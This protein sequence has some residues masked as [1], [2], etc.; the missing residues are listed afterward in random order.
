MT[1]WPPEFCRRLAGAGFFVIRY[2]NRDAGRSTKVRAPVS[3][4]TVVRAFFGQGP[5]PPYT[6]DDMAADGM[7]VLDDLG[8]PS[9]HVVGMSMGG[10]I[11]QTMALLHPDRVRSLT[12]IMSTTGRRS[13]GW[14][15]PRLLPLLLAR[16]EETREAYVTSSTR[17]WRIIGSPG[18]PEAVE[19]V[20]KRAG[21]TYDRGVNSA[22]VARQMIAVLRQP[23]RSDR[24]RG[25][26]VPALVIHGL[27]DR[28][29]H[30]SGGRATAE[31]LPDAE[32]LLVP[33]MG[34]DLPAE[35]YDTFV[36][37]IRRVAERAKV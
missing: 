13:V 22:A 30:V 17:F 29:V 20:R 33:G 7:G 31:A 2:D 6:L 16:S 5:R 14:Q 3:R 12:S 11:A 36:D 24:L 19:A 21:E 9:A 23:D 35:L 10:M 15:D 25:L 18:Y 37:A 1:W 4:R 34:H 28:M 8:L 26:A 27:A 32:L